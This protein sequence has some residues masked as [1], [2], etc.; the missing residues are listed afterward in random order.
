VLV[1]KLSSLG[2]VI[3]TLPALGDA[4]AALRGVRFDWVVEEGFAEI[5]AW[6]SAVDAVIPIALRR[7]RK[8]PVREFSFAGWRNVRR[9]LRACDYDVVI[10]AQGLIKSAL[11][12]GL[13]RGPR[14][15][16]DRASAREGLAARSYHHRIRVPRDMHA[17]ERTRTLFASALGY[18]VPPQPGDYGLGGRR[19]P[20][21]GPARLV[22]FHGTARVE[23]LWPEQQWAALAGLAEAA[24]YRVLLPWG[25]EDEQL[26]AHRIA[27]VGSNTEVLPRMNLQELKTLLQGVNGAVAVDTGL[28]HLA[29][30]LAVPTVSLYAPTST[31]L[32]GAY[33]CNQTHLESPLAVSGATP[34]LLMQAITAQECWQ[35]LQT[36]MAQAR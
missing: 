3:H 17:V 1:V 36:T 4:A 35:A 30:A 27:R 24:G 14:H 28:C 2:D 5:P 22:F 13:A 10:D 26:R 12:A 19:A 31:R 33:G 15:G 8:H 20:A 6:H 25:S 16:P 23:K 18:P 32:V 34:A 11:V 7:W 21:A 29:A 9:A